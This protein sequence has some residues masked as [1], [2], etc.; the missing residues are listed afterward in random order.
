MYKVATKCHRFSIRIE[1]EIMKRHK[2]EIRDT[3]QKRGVD[4]AENRHRGSARPYTLHRRKRSANVSENMR[5]YT[6]VLHL[7][8]SKTTPVYST[9]RETNP[10]SRA[11]E[12][13]CET[14]AT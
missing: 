1:R 5:Q 9:H 14:H 3:M 2:P 10:I 6:T 7:T 12:Q 8:N 13:N 11:I 4:K